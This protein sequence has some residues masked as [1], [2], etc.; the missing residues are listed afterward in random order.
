VPEL[1]REGLHDF[2]D[3]VQIGQSQMHDQIAAAYFA[4]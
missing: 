2:T 4:H 3:E 1:S